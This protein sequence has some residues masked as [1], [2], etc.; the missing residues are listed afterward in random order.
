MVLLTKIEEKII[1]ETKILSHMQRDENYPKVCDN[2][3]YTGKH[4][5]TL[6]SICNIRYKTPK[7]LPVVFHNVSNYDY[8]FII[9]EFAE[10]FEG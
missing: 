7:E 3:H 9:K 1:Q 6:H 2:C 8:H 4:R 10:G 5:G